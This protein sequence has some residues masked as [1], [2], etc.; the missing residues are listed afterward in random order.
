MGCTQ[1]KIENEEAV[2]RCKERKHFMKEA[3]SARNAFAAAHFAYAM[4]L[5]NTGAALSDYA[6]G[7]VQNPQL[8]FQSNASHPSSSVTAAAAASA[9]AQAPFDQLKPPPPPTL[10]GFPAP[11][12]RA[13]SMPEFVKTSKTR[14]PNGVGSPIMEE[15]DADEEDEIEEKLISRK[16]SSSRNKTADHQNV[17]GPTSPERPA[18]QVQSSGVMSELHDQPQQEAM[19]D[20]F[21]NV[22]GQPGSTLEEVKHDMVFDEK[23]KREEYVEEKVNAAET[24]AVEE[25]KVAAVAPPVEEEKVVAPVPPTG[26][27]G[28]VGRNLKRVKATG[29]GG[30]KKMVKGSVNLLQIFTE[31]D[32]HFLKA[33]ESAHDVSKMLEATRLHYHSNFAD[34]RGHIDH[35]ARVMRV[36][37]WN[38]SFRGMP[39]VDD[40]KDDFDSEEHETHATVLDKLLAWEK[41]LYDEVKAG[42][43]MKFEYQRKVAS[44]N[45][46]KRRGTNSESL[47]K[48]KAT[49][50]HLHTRYIV[51]MQ[52]MDSTVLEINRLRDEQ[53]YPKLVQLV[54]GMAT[55]WGAMH[56][57]H[58]QQSKI[59]FQLKFLDISQSPKET[60]VHHSERT[61]QLWAVVQDWHAQFCKLMDHQKEY[62]KAL[63]NWLKLNLIPIESSL[64]EKVSSPP[65]VATP[66]IQRLLITWHDYLG[67]LPDEGARGAISNFAAIINSIMHQQ[68]DE[69]KLKAK[70]EEI[71]KELLRKTRQFEDWYQK[72][73]Q[74][75]TPENVDPEDS[76]HKDAVQ[77]RQ[78]ALDLMKKQLEEEEEAYQRQCVQVREKSLAS[79]RTH[80]PEL[81]RAMSDISLACSRMYRDLRNISQL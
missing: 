58:E 65:R 43:L 75:R 52:S 3:V 37:T 70:C 45:K 29:G 22:H 57:H 9:S 4:S 78:F 41:K 17:V 14:E 42:E 72:Y 32:D 21:F 12:Q 77:D 64:K 6:H 30:E 16:R 38:R 49:V 36:I 48:I 69:L 62:I 47:E 50:S 33:S 5:K 80:L 39:N 54:D 8:A 19:Y 74:R 44:L 15:T 28:S 68:E 13:A 26:E 76:M 27:G 35:S 11:L 24:A 2:T 46:Q 34:N 51:D 79:L 81:F 61:M 10:Q 67:T 59:V 31:L 18:P 7:E 73:M 71:N 55:M 60:T 23:P 40:V 1:S 56:G 53:L 63:N 25:E 66:P 20:F